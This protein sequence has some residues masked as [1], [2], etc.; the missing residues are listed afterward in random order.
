MGYKGWI[1]S[2]YDEYKKRFNDKYEPKLSKI[3]TIKK[4]VKVGVKRENILPFLT[5]M[6]Y[7]VLII[8]IFTLYPFK[9]ISTKEFITLF[10]YGTL[11]FLLIYSPYIYKYEPD[12]KSYENKIKILRDILNER[13]IYNIDVVSELR[14]QT[15]GIIYKIRKLKIFAI[16][17][18]LIAL[19][20]F[21]GIGEAAKGLTGEAPKG[22]LGEVIS[23]SIALII[24][25]VPTVYSIYSVLTIVPNNR[26][27]RRKD[28]HELLKILMVYDFMSKSPTKVK[29][30]SLDSIEEIQEKDI[31]S[32]M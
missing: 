1:L 11:S 8:A 29:Q 30:D 32:D 14:D 2:I 21:T 10:A 16:L 20:I 26:I 15:G 9:I 13:K 17:N 18:T 31:T 27:T 5:L 23:F 25:S 22:V 12:L 7:I 24:I 28:F 19:G 4:V 6:V 3:E